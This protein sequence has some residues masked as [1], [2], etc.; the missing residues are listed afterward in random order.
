MVGISPEIGGT[1]GA[2]VPLPVLPDVLLPLAPLPDVPP[3]LPDPLLEEEPLLP[4]EPLP[5]LLAPRAVN[6]VL[7]TGHSP[8]FK[9][10]DLKWI[11]CL[12]VLTGTLAASMSYAVTPHVI[13]ELL[14][15]EYP[16]R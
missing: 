14:S 15:I 4:L 12:P 16:K 8:P 6:V 3:L 9:F 7:T 13:A 2:V 5:V 10:H 1:G 11:V